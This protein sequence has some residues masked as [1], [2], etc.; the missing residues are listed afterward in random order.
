[1]IIVLQYS[2][3]ERDLERVREI[4]DT[5]YDTTDYTLYN[6]TPT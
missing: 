6:R 1:L 2:L 5:E 4:G 3:H